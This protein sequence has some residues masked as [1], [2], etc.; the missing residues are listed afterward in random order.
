MIKKGCLV[1]CLLGVSLSSQAVEWYAGLDA[2]Y[3]QTKV[4]STSGN[5]KF[6]LP[7]VSFRFGAYLQPQLGVEFYGLSGVTDGSD[8][9][10]KLNVN[11]SVGVTTRFE[12]P[13][14]EGGKIFFLI[15][16]GWTQLDM[17]RSQTGSPGKQNFGDFSLGGGFEFKLGK[18]SPYYLSVQA[19]RYYSGNDISLNGASI[20]LRYRF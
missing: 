19:L 16:Y 8:K 15:G 1:V 20:G 6:L 7:A 17:N 18:S 4:T 11:Y 14:S 9:N 3:I 12:T 5:A 2:N 10:I 13:E